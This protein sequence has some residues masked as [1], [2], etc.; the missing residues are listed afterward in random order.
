ME[1][2]KK[3]REEINA[4]DKQMAELFEK[5]MKAVKDICEYKMKMGLPVEDKGR[6]AEVIFKN[7]EYISDDDIREYYVSFIKDTMAISRAYQ[8]RLME[9]LKVAYCGVEGAFAQIAARRIFPDAALVP[10]G[11]FQSA[12]DAVENAEC[13]CA[14]LPIENSYA[15]DVGQVIDILFEGSLFI[16]GAYDLGVVHNLLGTIDARIEDVKTVISHPQALAQCHKYIKEHGFKKEAFENTA[17]AAKTVS[18]KGDKSIAAIGSA[19]NAELYG[20][21]M[22]DHDIN[23]SNRNTTRF[24]VVSRSQNINKNRKSDRFIMMFTVSDET[25]SLSSAVNV[26]SESGFNM[27]VLRSRPIRDLSWQ[28]Y[29]FVEAI[30]DVH[31][32]KGQ[33]M[34]KELEKCCNK[35]KVIG[36]FKEVRELSE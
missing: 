17:V 18:E 27:S 20:L 21:K 6:E 16:N 19:T 24:A 28:Y 1:D 11:D 23:S 33:I 3:A 34:L 36:S 35:I 25:G 29:F 30:G 22:L 4:I 15:G 7:S 32:I 9:G 26:I 10:F 5:R 14:V 8:H 2:I 13:D 12:Y 31:S